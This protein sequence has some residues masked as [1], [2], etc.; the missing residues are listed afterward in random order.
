MS[1][2]ERSREFDVRPTSCGRV[3]ERRASG[4]ESAAGRSSRSSMGSFM[5]PG[6]LTACAVLVGILDA[7]ASSS[8]SDVRCWIIGKQLQAQ[9]DKTL[10][11]I[12]GQ[13][14]VFKGQRKG[15]K[16]L[17]ISSRHAAAYK[18]IWRIRGLSYPAWM[19][20]RASS[21]PRDQPTLGA[22]LTKLD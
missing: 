1:V 19:T 11:E 18:Q 20:R 14:G 22:E 13:E 6:Y 7:G 3:A 8:D 21:P 15:A 5:V 12:M 17:D 4:A 2:V 16:V 9:R 10:V